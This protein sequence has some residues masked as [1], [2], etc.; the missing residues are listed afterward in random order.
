MRADSYRRLSVSVPGGAGLP[1]RS[2]SRGLQAMFVACILVA[3][4]AMFALAESRKLDRAPITRARAVRRS[5]GRRGTRSPRSS[6]PTCDCPTSYAR[7]EFRLGKPGALDAWI[8]SPEGTVVK[9]IA[10]LQRRAACGA[11]LERRRRRR[12]SAYPTA[13]T[14]CASGR[15]RDDADAAGVRDR[16]HDAA[17]VPCDGRA[18]AADPER[19]RRRRPHRDHVALAVQLFD[20]RLVATSDGRKQIVPVFRH[21]KALLVPVAEG[22]VQHEGRLPREAQA[23]GRD[24]D[25]QPVGPDVAGNRATV[26]LGTVQV[27]R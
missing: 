21:S 16:A 10:R 23:G 3:S 24:L 13:A 14:G 19:R 7:I 17:E 22:L 25:A 15:R 18:E 12:A 2:V 26:A 4:T 20:V 11:A 5:R 6:R 8:V 1:S 27:T 9:Q